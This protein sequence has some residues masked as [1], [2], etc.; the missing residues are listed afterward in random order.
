[1][2]LFE[3]MARLTMP[4]QMLRK[5]IENG[6]VDNISFDGINQEDSPDFC[7]AFIASAHLD[8][9]EMTEREL[10]LL[11]ED[12]DRVYELLLKTLY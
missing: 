6:R 10:D 12:S 3:Q 2:D 5:I 11:N 1:M 4:D 9:I 7:D 8:G